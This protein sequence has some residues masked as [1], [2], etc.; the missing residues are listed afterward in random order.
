MLKVGWSSLYKHPLPAGHR[1]PMIKYD[2]IREQ[3]LY[4]GTLSPDH[5]FEPRPV[6]A[7][8]VS[9]T[10][11]PQYLQR[12]LDLDLS[13]SEIRKTGFPLSSTLVERELII[14]GG[15]IA[16]CDYALE[17]GVSLNIAGGT[18]HAYEHHGEG[19]CLLNDQAVAANYLLHSAKAR[20]V[21][22]I[23]LDVHQGNGT[24]SLFEQNEA[25]YTLSFH[26]AKNYPFKKEQSD[27]DVSFDDFVGDDTYLKVLQTTLKELIPE[28]DPD[29]VFY[30]SGVD[31]L[32]QDKLGRLSM[33]LAGLKS[34]DELVFKCCMD[35]DLPVVVCMGGGYS[36]SLAQIVEAHANTFR[37]AI[38]IYSLY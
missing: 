27:L 37:S 14:T 28:V 13:R 23:D 21:L 18:H 36:N 34:R 12:L 9:L 25:V 20:K 38:E 4:D 30:Q 2:L 29:F 33:T 11:S 24:A 31:A 19:F 26:G 10:H 7:D 16:C 8:I 32:A 22:I 1:F 6:S 3:L 5:F 17:Y 35:N 15:T